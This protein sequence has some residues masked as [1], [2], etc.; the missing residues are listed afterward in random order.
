MDLIVNNLCDLYVRVRV[1][2]QTDPI[3][4]LVFMPLTNSVTD[5]SRVAGGYGQVS[6]GPGRL[7]LL[8]AWGPQEV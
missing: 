2:H 1:H 7:R 8:R 3:F 6:E 5:E 4:R